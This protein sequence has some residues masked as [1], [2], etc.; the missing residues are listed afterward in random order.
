MYIASDGCWAGT[1][2]SKCTIVKFGSKI[3]VVVPL[4]IQLDSPAEAEQFTEERFRAG[5]TLVL[6]LGDNCMRSDSCA[7]LP[8]N[9]TLVHIS[10][11]SSNS[12]KP[13]FDVRV[14][15]SALNTASSFTGPSRF[16]LNL[17]WS[18]NYSNRTTCKR[19]IP[20]HFICMSNFEVM[21]IVRK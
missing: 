10:K 5:F 20:A 11:I 3:R 9:L 13:R 4:G 15:S 2:G 7:F 14:E 19:S 12:R 8:L 16:D 6:L 18:F 1:M 21:N 17:E